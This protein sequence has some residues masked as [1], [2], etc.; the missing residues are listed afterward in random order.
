MF[1]NSKIP[2][3]LVFF[4]PLLWVSVASSLSLV[5]PCAYFRFTRLFPSSFARF[6]TRSHFIA[7]HKPSWYRLLTLPFSLFLNFILRMSVAY[8]SY[9]KLSL[10]FQMIWEIFPLPPSYWFLV[11]SIVG[12]DQILWIVCLLR[13]MSHYV[14]QVGT[15]YIVQAVLKLMTLLPYLYKCWANRRLLVWDWFF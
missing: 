6:L 15:H 5:F 14:A 13:T 1:W 9:R 4:L 3:S 10:T 2:I 8:E 12:R 7:G 11:W